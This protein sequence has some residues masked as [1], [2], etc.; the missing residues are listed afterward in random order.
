[1][2]QLSRL[3]EQARTTR[4]VNDIFK[5]SP[6]VDLPDDAAPQDPLM[7][8]LTRLDQELAKSSSF[9]PLPIADLV[10]ELEAIAREL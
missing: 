2:S 6:S 8:S 3:I 10:A 1:M 4:R 7:A 5:I 9:A